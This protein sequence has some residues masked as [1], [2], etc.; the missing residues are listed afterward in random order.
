M[1]HKT[2]FRILWLSLLFHTYQNLCK[3]LS[4]PQENGNGALGL[5]RV[6]SANS[7]AQGCTWRGGPGLLLRKV[8]GPE[9]VKHKLYIQYMRTTNKKIHR[10]GYL[11]CCT[12]L[13]ICRPRRAPELQ[14]SLW[15]RG[16]GWSG[17]AR[18]GNRWL[19]LKNSRGKCLEEVSV[20]RMSWEGKFGLFCLVFLIGSQP[21]KRESKFGRGKRLHTHFPRFFFW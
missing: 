6:V 2:S 5:R 11:S 20:E 7:R 15:P 13:Q 1:Q 4:V 9:D 8:K 12:R 17:L 10:L 18:R 14:K 19:R 21:Q 3:V 16:S